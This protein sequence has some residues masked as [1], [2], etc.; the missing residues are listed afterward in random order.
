MVVSKREWFLDANEA[1][2]VTVSFSRHFL[3]HSAAPVA[4][5]E[6]STKEY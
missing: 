3:P 5:L 4:G 2:C 6:T 1:R